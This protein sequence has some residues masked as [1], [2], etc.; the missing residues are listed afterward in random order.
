MHIKFNQVAM[1]MNSNI[2]NSLNRDRYNLMNIQCRYTQHIIEKLQ[3]DITC[4]NNWKSCNYL[5]EML[6]FDV[7]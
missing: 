3:F 2:I 6:L 1:D 5:S 4:K 7:P